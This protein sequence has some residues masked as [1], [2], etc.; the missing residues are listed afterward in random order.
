MNVSDDENE[1]VNAQPGGA[2]NPEPPNAPNEADQD[3]AILTDSDSDPDSIEAVEAL[4]GRRVSLGRQPRRLRAILV[5][6]IK[7]V[8]GKIVLK[9]ILCSSD[10]RMLAIVESL[11]DAAAKLE[12]H[13]V[14]KQILRGEGRTFTILK[15]IVSW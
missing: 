5:R 14:E 8:I 7:D 11:A 10:A 1:Q 3:I 15:C 9:G 4:P 6:A 12:E 2:E 13:E